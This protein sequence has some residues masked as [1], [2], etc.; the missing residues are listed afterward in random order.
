MSIRSRRGQV[1]ALASLAMTFGLVAGSLS[2]PTASAANTYLTNP[3]GLAYA[4][5]SDGAAANLYGRPTGMVITGRCNR[6]APGFAT[7]RAN[8]AE[9]LAYLNVMQRPDGPVCAAD[10]EFYGGDLSRTPLWPYPTYG[11]R[12]N[13]PDTHMTD[14]RVGSAWI[15]QAVSYIEDLMVEDKVDGV[16]LDD[17]GARLWSSLANWGSWPQWERDAWTAGMVDLVRRL[18]ASR[19]ALNPRFIIV[20]NNVWDGAG[21]L[22]RGGEPYVDGIMLEGHASTSTY[23][24]D[25]AART[26]GNLGHRRVL[27]IADSTADARAWADVQGVTHVSDQQH[28]GTPSTPP[29]GFNRLTDRPKRFGRT[30]IATNSSGG[31]AANQ[32]RGSKFTLTEK[33]TLLRFA[34]YLDGGGATAGSQSV[35]MALYRDNAGVPGALVAQSGAGTV[36]AGSAGR[37][38]WFSGPATRL[39]PGA[40]WIVIHT[41]DTAGVAR[42]RGDG[43]AN[44]YAAIDQ[45]ADGPSSQFGTGWSGNVTLSVNVFYTVGY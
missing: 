39:D 29:I 26:Y 43:A 45:F 31:M 25:E 37:W 36:A 17:I 42:N 15:D 27:V 20:N 21:T 6:Y 5:G 38:M 18:D 14:M 19:R 24:R 41:G 11:A 33:G 40:Y 32:K 8:G 3:L 13:W 12:V 28:Y 34:A 2:V 10:T 44:W 9:V 30:D 1:A 35:R 16:F 23:H 7:A 4:V 22:G